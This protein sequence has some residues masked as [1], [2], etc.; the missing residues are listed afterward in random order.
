VGGHQRTN[1]EVIHEL[2]PIY[3]SI[4][5]HGDP[6]PTPEA[7]GLIAASYGNMSGPKQLKQCPMS[8]TE[9][10]KLEALDQP[11]MPANPRHPTE[12]SSN[13]QRRG[14]RYGTAGQ[15]AGTQAPSNNRF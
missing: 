5:M 13:H 14:L 4:D 12:S 15:D 2:L 11:G 1:E 7:H 8:S 6:H 3:A 9:L 10:D